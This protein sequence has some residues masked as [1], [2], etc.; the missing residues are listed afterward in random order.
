VIEVYCLV[1]RDELHKD[2]EQLC[3]HQAGPGYL[4]AATRM[5]FQRYIYLFIYIFLCIGSGFSH[6]IILRDCY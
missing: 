3:M 1:E 4:A 2:I 5:H 6:F